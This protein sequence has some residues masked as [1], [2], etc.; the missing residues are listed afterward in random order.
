MLDS[1]K[2]RLDATG[3]ISLSVDGIASGL[4]ISKKTLYKVFP[5]KEFLVRRLVQMVMAEA[6]MRIHTIVTSDQR[7]PEKLSHILAFFSI[8]FRRMDSDLGR[9]LH[10]RMPEVWQMVEQFREQKLQENVVKLLE[11]GV[12]E[13][14]IRP[15]ID[16][17]LFIKAFV[18]VAQAIIRPSTLLIDTRSP[19]QVL[20]QII[21]MMYTGIMTDAGRNEFLAATR[22]STS[23]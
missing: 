8:L 16:R 18:A 12:R 1:L 22:Q 15:D 5:S 20:T 4:G 14:V 9:E 10:Y 3:E 19:Q 7:L 17:D 11:Q 2:Q 23:V 6:A 21:T 13:E